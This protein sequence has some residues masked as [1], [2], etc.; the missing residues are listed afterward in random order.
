M[1]TNI[2][3]ACMILISVGLNTLGQVL[4]K[5]GASQLSTSGLNNLPLL[6]GLVAYGFSTIF[7][8]AVL[9]RFNLSTAY[10]VVLGLTVLFTTFSGMYWLGEKIAVTGWI[11]V[12]LM[13]SGISAIA[14]GKIS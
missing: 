5:Q 11:G 2:L 4:L 6:G 1:L 9:S 13:I 7:Y 3:F 8:I 14:F 10:P 12:G